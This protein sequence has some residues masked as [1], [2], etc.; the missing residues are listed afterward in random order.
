MYLKIGKSVEILLIII[1]FVLNI[2]IFIN[3]SHLQTK[4]GSLSI[5]VRQII[6]IIKMYIND[7]VYLDH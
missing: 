1:E 3:H 4:I 7:L 6:S 5:F 2:H